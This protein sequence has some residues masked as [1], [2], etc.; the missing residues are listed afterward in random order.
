MTETA[1]AIASGLA[2]CNV[3]YP[4]YGGRGGED[5]R[6]L[7]RIFQRELGGHPPARIEAAFRQHMRVAGRFP[8]LADIAGLLD[9]VTCYRLDYGPDGFGALYTAGH[10]YVQAQRRAGV[11]MEGRAVQVPAMYARPLMMEATAAPA[12]PAPAEDQAPGPRATSSGGLRKISY[13]G[14]IPF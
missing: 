10:P 7:A 12:L 4:A 3:M 11:S 1:R 8:T 6:L 13:A 9:P 2:E 14:E 5:L